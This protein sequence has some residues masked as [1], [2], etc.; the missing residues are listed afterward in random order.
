MRWRSPSSRIARPPTLAAARS[1][2]ALSWRPSVGPAGGEQR[3]ARQLADQVGALGAQAGQAERRQLGLGRLGGDLER[4]GLR[5]GRGDHRVAEGAPEGRQELGLRRGDRVEGAADVDVAEAQPLLGLALQRVLEPVAALERAVVALSVD[6]GLQPALVGEHQVAVDDRGH[7]VGAAEAAVARRPRTRPRCPGPAPSAPPR[8]PRRSSSVATRA[9]AGVS[10]DAPPRPGLVGEEG[11]PVAQPRLDVLLEG[12]LGVLLAQPVLDQ[13]GQALAGAARAGELARERV[14][15]RPSGHPRDRARPRRRTGPR[16][17]PAWRAARCR[18]RTRRSGRRR[19]RTGRRAA[20]VGAWRVNLAAALERPATSQQERPEQRQQRARASP[21]NGSEPPACPAAVTS[22]ARRS[23]V[24]LAVS[25]GVGRSR[26]VRRQPVSHRPPAS[27]V[28]TYSR[29]PEPTVKEAPARSSATSGASARDAVSGSPGGPLHPRR[30]PAAPGPA[31]SS[32]AVARR[33]SPAGAERRRA[34]PGAP[35]RRAFAVLRQARP[36][37]RSPSPASRVAVQRRASLHGRGWACPRW[38]GPTPARCAGRPRRR[39]GC[40]RRPRP[41][42]G[43]VAGSPAVLRGPQLRDPVGVVV[44]QARA[45]GRS[46][47]GHEARSSRGSGRPGAAGGA[48]EVARGVPLVEDRQPEVVGLEGPQLAA[49]LRARRSGPAARS[50][51][52]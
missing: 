40:G 49:Q 18:S 17:G 22:P 41:E 2:P 28:I 12:D 11:H 25:A 14:D 38:P 42:A 37:A 52:A 45:A 4:V 39:P 35:S 29:V 24:I 5:G 33:P 48:E 7:L 44:A 19:A 23:G 6:D 47:A 10:R 16:P 3:V 8:W 27:V 32:P 30:P 26:R 50:G 31:A 51:P 34:W 46:A 13:L 43:L 20:R 1:T 9:A 15:A 36:R 21:V